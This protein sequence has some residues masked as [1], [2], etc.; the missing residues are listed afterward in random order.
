MLIITIN[1]T[2]QEQDQCFLAISKTIK[3]IF[4]FHSFVYFDKANLF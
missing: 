3:K 2:L 1:V 4:K